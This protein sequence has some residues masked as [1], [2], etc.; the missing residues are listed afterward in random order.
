MAGMG[1]AITGLDAFVDRLRERGDRAGGL[2][3]PAALEN[4]DTNHEVSVFELFPPSFMQRYTEHPDIEA[5]F[6][7]TKWEPADVESMAV[8]G[9]ELD[10]QVNQHTAFGSWA[11][12]ED[13]AVAY[14][15][16]RTLLGQGDTVQQE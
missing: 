3:T 8:V 16:E 14:W 15:I 7:G 4:L 6:A 10:V 13:A 1:I 2:D 9:N 5:F 12:V 11:R